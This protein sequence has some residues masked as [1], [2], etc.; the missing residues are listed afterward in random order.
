MALALMFITAKRC[1]GITGIGVLLAIAVSTPVRAQ[2][3]AMPA[4]PLDTAGR[5]CGAL[6]ALP[7][8]VTHYRYE[9][10][11]RCERPVTFFWRCRATD[12]EHSLEIPGKATQSATCVKATAAAGEIVFRFDPP[13][14]G[15]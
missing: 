13:G 7:A 4:E 1:S 14:T 3:P 10:A 9:V 2:T 6:R 11:N 5:P 15:N 12:T 8:D